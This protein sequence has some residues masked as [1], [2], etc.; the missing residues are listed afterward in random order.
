MADAQYDSARVRKTVEEDGGEPIIPHRRSSRI[1]NAL[2]G[3]KDFIVRGVK[4]LVKLFQKRVSVERLFSRAKEWLLLN[5]LRVRGLEQ[6]FIHA[7]LS[8]SAMLVVAVT[9][10][11]Q[12]KPS[13]IRSIKHYTTQ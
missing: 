12:H 8:F 11:R 6:A 9:A 1:K 10:V 3:G 13:L 5:H 4:R 7:C 2:K